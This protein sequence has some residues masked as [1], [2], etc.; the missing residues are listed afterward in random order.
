MRGSAPSIKRIAHAWSDDP[1]SRWATGPRAVECAEN[2]RWWLASHIKDV[3][4]RHPPPASPLRRKWS[5]SVL[6]RAE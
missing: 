6:R 4:Q 5:A 2:F 1:P 3:L